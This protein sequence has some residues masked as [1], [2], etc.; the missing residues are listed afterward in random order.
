MT[1]DSLDLDGLAQGIMVDFKSF[2]SQCVI[3]PTVNM[4]KE[5]VDIC[6][7]EICDR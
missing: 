2:S 4:S 7:I 5:I 3:P 1:E 6:H